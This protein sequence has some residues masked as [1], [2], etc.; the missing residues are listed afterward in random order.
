ME[1]FLLLNPGLKSRFPFIFDFDDFKIDQLIKIAKQMFQKRE[2][3]L[4]VDA[5]WQ[6]RQHLYKKMQAKER[7]FSNARYIRN[8]VE[9][10]IRMHAVRVLCNKNLSPESLINIT[11]LDLHFNHE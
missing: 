7:N 9:H 3:K 2:Y 1:Q 6:L 4:T 10:S 11:E 8:I 5:E